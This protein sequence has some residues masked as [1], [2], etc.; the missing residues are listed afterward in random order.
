MPCCINEK[1]L[2]VLKTY[3]GVADIF[4]SSQFQY[5]TNALFPIEDH[6]GQLFTM[7]RHPIDRTIVSYYK[8]ITKLG[9]DDEQMSLP[10]YIQSSLFTSNWLTRTLSNVSSSSNPT[11]KDLDLAKEI[12]RR[13]CLIGIYEDLVR[14]VDL[15]N[16][17]FRWNHANQ[18]K[19]EEINQCVTNVY[20]ESDDE[21]YLIRH[22]LEDRGYD[23]GIGG[24]IYS[25]IA[26]RNDF[27]M[28]LYW[29]AFDL[30]LAQVAR[31]NEFYTP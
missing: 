27:D 26:Q 4:S 8:F 16:N 20:H 22:K 19:R 14:S 2:V 21:K 13:K 11:L 28:R 1:K 5:V 9:K 6:K 23:I 12:L 29:Y 18:S 25:M 10:Q 24:E 7:L 3:S 15:F 31:I 30:H 17:Y